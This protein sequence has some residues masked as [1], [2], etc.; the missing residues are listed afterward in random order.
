MIEALATPLPGNLIVHASFVQATGACFVTVCNPG[1]RD[2]WL[3]AKT[4][5]GTVS[6]GSV[7]DDSVRVD[8]VNDRLHVSSHQASVV[9]SDES[10]IEGLDL[11]AL[12]GHPCQGRALDIFRRYRSVLAQEG[13]RPGR[14]DAIQHHISLDGG[15]VRTQPYRKVPWAQLDELRQHLRQLLA[16]DVIRPSVS[17]Y[18]SPIVLVRKKSGSLRMCV[19]YRALNSHTIKCAYPLPRIDESLDAIGGATIFSSM[20][21]QSA[22]YQVEIAEEDKAKTAFTTPIGLFEFNRMAF[23]LCNAPATYQRLMHDVFR[24]D[25]FK[26]L[27]VYLDDILVYSKTVDEHLERLELVLS[28]LHQH[29]LKLEPKKCQFFKRKVNFLGHEISSAGI[30]TDQE[31]VRAVTNW[32]VPTTVKDVR[33]FLGFCSY[34]RRFVKGFAQIA[35]PLHQLVADCEPGPQR[36][37]KKT[38]SVERPWAEDEKLQRAF[39]QLKT[40]LTTAPVLGYADYNLPFVLET[41]ALNDG[42]G[43]VL[44][45][46]QDGRSKVIAYASRGLR[47]GEKTMS[48]YSSKKLE[49]LA[50]KWAVTDKL[51]DYLHGAHFTVFTDNNPLTHILTQKKLPALEQRWV[52]AL[53]SFDFDIKYRPGKSNTHAD[54]LSRRKHVTEEAESVS[55]CMAMKLGCSAIPTTL[56]QAI[57]TEA[58]D[59]TVVQCSMLEVTSTLPGYKTADLVRMQAADPGIAALLR[60]HELQRQPTPK[61]RCELARSALPWLKQRRNVTLRNG[62]A[63]RVAKEPSGEETCQLLVP[64]S[65]QHDVLRGLHDN[66]GHQGGERTEA[67]IRERFYWPAIRESVA[68][69]LAQC[70]RCTLSKMPYKTIRTPMESV[71]ATKPLEVVCIDYTKL[72]RA[73]GMENV[74]V[75]TDVFTKMTVAVATR[76]QTAQTTAKALTQAWFSRFGAPARLHSDQGANFESRVIR[77]LCALYG[78]KKSRTTPYHPQGNAQTERFN[79]TLHGLL[80]SLSIEQKAKWPEH[81]QHVVD[82]YNVT[83]QATTGYSPFYLMF[84]RHARLPVDMLFGEQEASEDEP[85]VTLHQR[86]LQEAYAVVN[87]RLKQAA[88]ERKKIFDRKARDLPIAVGIEVYM[89]NHPP[90]RNKIQD[91]F[92]DRVYR[93]VRRHGEQNVYTVEPADGFG[94]P[95]TV[96]RAELKICERPLLRETTSDLPEPQRRRHRQAP[97]PPRDARPRDDSSSS[98]EDGFIAVVES[99]DDDVDDVDDVD[100]DAPP[101]PVRS[102]SSSLPTSDDDRPDEVV[103]RRSSRRTA[104]VHPNVHRLPR[105]ACCDSIF[106]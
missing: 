19:D 28:K 34:Y 35:K 77:R 14:T 97:P 26:V 5:L 82:A 71:L 8:F 103:V 64:K 72:E 49:L 45:Q 33:S 39:D 54:G 29:G 30:A 46:V 24:D 89:R 81:L 23:G 43:A 102:P 13:D 78:I 3:R 60:Y 55:S 22:Y 51:Q 18:S 99:V 11:S 15:P 106:W 80:R 7:E 100:N 95:R 38:T 12:D 75:M 32:P 58:Q 42:L 85:W 88:A 83:P 62:L 47:G 1:V 44:S 96:G 61:E 67:L 59:A 4:R 70:R 63:Y 101:S 40:A 9:K 10:P 69:W 84:G 20:D 76:D 73:C 2:V 56:R 53:A 98:S 27:L 87:R 21:L 50:L 57:L 66:A 31:K 94:N 41:D 68:E 93:V 6:R 37:R 48:N 25:I 36:K 17:P 90:G 104:G 86:R 65:L 91:A 92:R 74:L 79:R 52:N 105:S 16:D